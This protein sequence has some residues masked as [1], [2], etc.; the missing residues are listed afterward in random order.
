MKIAFVIHRYAESIVG[1]SEF[2]CRRI[3]EQMA[4][5]HEVEVL[6]TT[7]VDYVTWKDGFP[8]GVEILNGVKV[9]RFKIKAKRNLVRFKEISDLCFY[10][11]GHTADDEREWVRANGPETPD[12]VQYIKDHKAE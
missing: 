1:G 9:R 3:A 11:K 4:S 8:T 12:L 6:T 7:A 2:H 10:E 5:R